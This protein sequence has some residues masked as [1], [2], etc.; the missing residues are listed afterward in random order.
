MDYDGFVAL[1]SALKQKT[2]LQILNVAG[3][4]FGERGYMALSKSLPKIKDCSK[5]TLR[6]MRA[7]NQPGRYC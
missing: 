4:Q 2:S 1:V 7:F 6:R 5:S 3:N